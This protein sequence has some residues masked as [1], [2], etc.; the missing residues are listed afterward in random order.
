VTV[1][2]YTTPSCPY[3]TMVKEFL[4]ANNVAFEEL[5]VAVDRDAAIEMVKR[6]GQ[7]G[8]P[9]VDVNGTIIVGFN[10]GAIVKAL[11]G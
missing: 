11:N 2:V 6:S 4:R 1:K 10:S 8:V 5:N 3:C 9:V 7:M